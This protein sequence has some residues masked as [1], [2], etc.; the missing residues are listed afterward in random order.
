[1]ASGGFGMTAGELIISSHLTQSGSVMAKVR[2]TIQRIERKEVA[3]RLALILMGFI[4]LL[5]WF[6]GGWRQ[7]IKWLLVIASLLWIMLG[8][9]VLSGFAYEL[10]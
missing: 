1:M 5:A 2:I 8:P 7:A 9:M 3:M 10:C 6:E 4:G